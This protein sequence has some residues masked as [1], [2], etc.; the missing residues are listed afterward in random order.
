MP[1]CLKKIIFASSTEAQ[2]ERK[3][4][5]SNFF[6]DQQGPYVERSEKSFIVRSFAN[7]DVHD[8]ICNHFEIER[9]C[10]GTITIAFIID[11]GIVTSSRCVIVLSFLCSL[12]V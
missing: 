9:V 8:T 1:V 3:T 5:I 6:R 12:V 10:D 7:Q 2:L 11:N 4:W